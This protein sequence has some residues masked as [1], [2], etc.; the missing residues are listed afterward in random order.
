VVLPLDNQDAFAGS[1]P[2]VLAHVTAAYDLLAD[3][4]ADG[5]K[6]IR[7][8]VER[9]RPRLGTDSQTGWPCFVPQPQVAGAL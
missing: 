6:G 4:P 8:M 9:A 2:K 5:L 3:I 1:F 7:I